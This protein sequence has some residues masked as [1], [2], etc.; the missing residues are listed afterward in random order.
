MILEQNSPTV[1]FDSMSDFDKIISFESL[2]KAH[3]RARLGKRWKN[4]VIDFEAN[5]AKN[6]W[7]LH[8]DLK[9]AKYQVGTYHKFMIYDPKEREIQAISYRDRIV[10]HSLCDNYLIPLLEKRL[11]FDNCACRKGKGTYFAFSRLK[12]FI[13]EYYRQN[14]KQGYFVKI[15]V[16]KYFPSIDHEV[17]IE[18]LS[19]IIKDI[20]VFA[21]VKKIISS[22]EF[23]SGKGLPMGN[24]T[25]QCFALL[26]LDCIDRCI[27]EECRVKYYLRYMDDMILIVKDKLEARRI[28]GTVSQKLINLS[29]TINPKS[30]CFPFK[31][32]VDFL[33]WHFFISASGKIVQKLKKDV[34]KRIV[35]RVKNTLYCIDAGVIP[36]SRKTVLVVSYRGHLS[37]GNAYSFYKKLASYITHPPQSA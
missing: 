23:L 10:Q 33:G 8:Y 36:K 13:H 6:L 35:N 34:K 7:A 4:E 21:L 15:D 25:S 9:Y 29:L 27:K 11:I 2:Y 14:G 28:L 37:Y 19:K 32:G 22:Y 31:N 16:R 17:L 5:L 20:Q 30:Q 12:K 3:R 26:Y 24:Q 1:Q 18:K